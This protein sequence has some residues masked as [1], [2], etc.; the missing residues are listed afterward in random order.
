ML[1]EAI[2]D[3]PKI[4]SKK[5]LVK[6]HTAGV[7]PLDWRIR[8]G[9]MKLITG[10]RFPRI[11]GSDLSG[12]VVEVGKGVREFKVGDEIVSMI[13]VMF[14]AGAYAEY[15]LV[16]EKNTILKPK[17]L[18]FT[19]AGC[20]P[21]SAMAALQVLKDKVHLKRDQSIL[22]NGAS[23]GVGTFAVQIA[24]ILGA[25]ATGV[26]SGKNVEL[27]SSLGASDVIDYTKE[28]CLTDDRLYDV[29][30][31]TVGNLTFSE[32]K[33]SL[34]NGGTY[35]TIVPSVK[36]IL[37]MVMTYIMPGKKCRFVSVMPKKDSLKWLKEEVEVEKLKVVI[38]RTYPLESAKEAHEY[39]EKGH[40]KG[41]IAL[42]VENDNKS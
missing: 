26:C 8:K 21:C 36:K 5:M 33:H 27:V 40:A 32:C 1:E 30:F 18:S 17:N 6:V 42:T 10:R 16:D 7:N 24:N 14:N 23:G 3:I 25:K 19:E 15:V 39:I 41:K 9:E 11:L 4:K 2:I 22:I 38:D 20:L 12:T 28:D 34:V 31:D 29:I 35:V 37:S 13:N